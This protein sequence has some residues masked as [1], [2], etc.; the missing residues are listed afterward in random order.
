M[1]CTGGMDTLDEHEQ[2]ISFGNQCEL[3]TVYVE[4]VLDNA[5]AFL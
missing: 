1:N 2:P 3:N 4:I 5:Y